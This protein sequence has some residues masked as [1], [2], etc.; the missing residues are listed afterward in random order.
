MPLRA[1]RK[2]AMQLQAGQR[3]G[4]RVQQFHF[5]PLAFAANRFVGAPQCL[6]VLRFPIG[7]IDAHQRQVAL[8]DRL[9][10]GVL[11]LTAE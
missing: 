11:A 7:G 1:G 4:T 10:T 5:Q 9:V 3:R 8:P 2:Q 6:E